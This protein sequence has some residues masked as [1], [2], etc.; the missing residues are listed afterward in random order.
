VATVTDFLG[1]ANEWLMNLAERLATFDRRLWVQGHRLVAIA[2]FPVQ[3]M[4][5][6]LLLFVGV[7]IYLAVV[8]L[9]Y[10]AVVAAVTVPILAVF[11]GLAWAANG[12]SLDFNENGAGGSGGTVS[13]GG[14]GFCSTHQC[15][16]NFSN[17]NG[18][19]VQCEDG[20]WSHSGGLSGACS[21]H[22]GE[23]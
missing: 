4:V 17:G 15:T 19:V 8:C 23:R 14:G 7:P 16:G 2:A 22:G 11:V 18:Y 1:R 3:V 10:V 13:G 21:Y 20:E 9:G 6:L 5:W 12:F